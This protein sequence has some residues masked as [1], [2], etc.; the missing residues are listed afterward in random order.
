PYNGET[1]ITTG[2]SIEHTFSHEREGWLGN[3]ANSI[4]HTKR[5]NMSLLEWAVGLPNV[6]IDDVK[7]VIIQPRLRGEE[8]GSQEKHWLR[9][10]KRPG[11]PCSV[12]KLRLIKPPTIENPPLREFEEV[13]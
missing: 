11:V 8:R 7:R 1:Q 12:P 6:R 10:R 13:D 2:R 4:V 9:I 3:I 5:G